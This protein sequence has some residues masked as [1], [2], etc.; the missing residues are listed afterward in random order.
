MLIE[1][2]KRG[3]GITAG[4]LNAISE[5]IRRNAVSIS[6]LRRNTGSFA[7][8][9][10]LSVQISNGLDVDIAYGAVVGLG[11]QL[12]TDN[13][14]QRIIKAETIDAGKHWASFAVAG[15]KIVK[16]AIGKA[17][18]FGVCFALVNISDVDH[19]FAN[20]EDDSTTLV[21]ASFG[22]VKILWTASTSP[23]LAICIVQIGD[24]F[25]PVRVKAVAE[26]AD[27]MVSVQ[28]ADAEGNL[29]DGAFDV[30]NGED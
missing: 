4:K 6:D 1:N 5:Q 26:P 17:M 18:Y 11:S 8:D 2:W 3:D 30:Y 10:G 22:R 13:A 25:F 23:E 7:A 9:N 12:I 28:L 29:I 27:G 24:G 16:G 19:K 15:E 14:T 20:I 21:S